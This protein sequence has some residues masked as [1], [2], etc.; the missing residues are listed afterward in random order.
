MILDWF[1]SKEVDEFADSIV[2]DLVRRLPPSGVGV[3]AK[4]AADRLRKT[5]DAIFARI[6]SFARSQSLN[7]YK[8]ARLGNRIKWALM[9]AGYPSDF[10]DTLTLEL[11]TVVTLV[12]RER[13]KAVS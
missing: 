13:K 8:K 10:V 3:P 2:A 1:K 6:E 7:I 12:S 4:K 9:E 5:H 11:V